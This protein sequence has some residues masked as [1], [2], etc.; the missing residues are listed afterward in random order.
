MILDVQTIYLY[1]VLILFNYEN[2][3]LVQI[4]LSLKTIIKCLKKFDLFFC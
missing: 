3:F 1:Y 4:I 2:I